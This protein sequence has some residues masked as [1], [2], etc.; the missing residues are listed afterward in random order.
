MSC[1]AR[2]PVYILFTGAFFVRQ[3]GLVVFS[4]YFLGIVLAV[5]I[6]RL[7]KGL[8]FKQEVAPLIMELP[9]YH[10]PTLRSILTH[11]WERSWL[12]IRK[13]GTIIAVAVVLIWFLGSLPWGV[14]YASEASVIGRIGSL[15]APL[16]K[17]AGFGYWWA[18]VALLAGIV[19]K[20]IVVS[21][22]ATIHGV[23]PDGLVE[24]IRHQF[25]PLSAYAFMVMSLLYI[26]CIATIAAIRREAGWRWAALSIGYTTVLGWLVAVAIYQ[27]GSLFT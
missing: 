27:V 18:A 3:R 20:E 16:F 14:E 6:A 8:F 22:M 5:L 26:P 19:A 15:M 10:L 25:T 23:N 1:S 24:V 9:P 2:L 4:L 11:M 13:A 17:P 12:F 21:T 7:F